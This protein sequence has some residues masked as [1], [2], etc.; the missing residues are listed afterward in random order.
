MGNIGSEK[1]CT[2]IMPLIYEFL[3]NKPRAIFQQDNAPLH[4]SKATKA[5]L[6]SYNIIPIQ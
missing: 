5:T 3:K 6:A 1:Y 4:T 2:Y